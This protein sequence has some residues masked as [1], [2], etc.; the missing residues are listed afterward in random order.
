MN[1]IRFQDN[2]NQNQSWVDWVRVDENTPPVPDDKKILLALIRPAIELYG[3]FVKEIEP[4][5]SHLFIRIA[6]AGTPNEYNF[7]VPVKCRKIAVRSQQF[8]AAQAGRTNNWVLG[9]FETTFPSLA[10]ATK[11]LKSLKI[12]DLEKVLNV[13]RNESGESVKIFGL[14]LSDASLRQWGIVIVVSIQIYFWL[15]LS[16]F[17]GALHEATTNERFPWIAFLRIANR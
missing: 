12:D 14:E 4:G 15:H 3:D 9:S 11:D 8:L 16:N 17:Y 7:I 1:Q 13:Q 5:Y 10:N 2:S 6:R